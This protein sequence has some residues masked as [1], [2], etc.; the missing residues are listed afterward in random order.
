MKKEVKALLLAAGFGTRLRPITYKTPKCL[1]EINGKPL[2]KIWIDNLKLARINSI[3][4]NT[5]YLAEKVEVFVK[6]LN[7]P[8]IEINLVKEKFLLGTAGTLI[9]NKGFFDDSTGLLIHAD[10][11]TSVDLSRFIKAH[12]QRPGNCILTMLTFD[13]DQP[14]NCGVVDI[15][16]NGIVRGFYEK[17]DNPPSKIANGAIY[18]FDNDFLCWIEK[19]LPSAKDFSTEILPNLIGKIYTWHTDSIYIDIGTPSALNKAQN[20]KF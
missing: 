7:D 15:D 14:K 13:T 4:I 17:N 8:N 3:L 19:N 6:E 11:F 2:L 18:A 16:K 5:H 20:C 1:V 10:N 12:N 9:K